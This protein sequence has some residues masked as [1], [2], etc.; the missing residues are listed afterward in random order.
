M[1]QYECFGFSISSSFPLP[2]PER[3]SSLAGS[4][5]ASDVTI[6]AGDP[7]WTEER[8]EHSRDAGGARYFV[9][10]EGILVRVPGLVDFF[11][12]ASRI[13]VRGDRGLGGEE[14][15]DLAGRVALGFVLQLRGELALHGA[16]LSSGGAALVLVGERGAGK[17]T[18]TA[19]LALRGF[20]AL[21]DDVVVVDGEGLVSPGLHRC[22]L[23]RDALLGLEPGLDFGA[24]RRDR[25]GKFVLSPALVGAAAPLRAIVA[26][27]AA[28]VDGIETREVSGYEK[29]KALLGHIHSLE[30]VGSPAARL[31][32]AAS[33]LR[34]APLF[35]LRRPTHRLA[36]EEGLDAI[37]GIFQEVSR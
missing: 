33:S 2:I 27:S 12:S 4:M 28:D 25:D 8:L 37:E 16:A 3:E 6:E 9:L 26:L 13:E 35:E 10:D 19:G 15:G 5:R 21:S 11:V 20:G 31:R 14:L 1:L 22:R 29:L 34:A 32:L 17:S 36:L 7:P 23:N 24:V 18:A 30:C